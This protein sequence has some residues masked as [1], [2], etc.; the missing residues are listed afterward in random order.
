M[1][2]IAG[3]MMGVGWALV[4]LVGKACL[5]EVIYLEGEQVGSSIVIVSTT[6]MINITRVTNTTIAIYK[7]V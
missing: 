1:A 2:H 5:V 4:G 3:R 7:V 6:A